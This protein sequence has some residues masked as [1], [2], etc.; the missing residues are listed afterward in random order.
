MAPVD[1]FSFQPAEEPVG[2]GVVRAASRRARAVLKPVT[3]VVLENL[4]G[5]ISGKMDATCIYPKMVRRG[6]SM[7]GSTGA[8]RTTNQRG[9]G[10]PYVQGPIYEIQ[11]LARGWA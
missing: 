4:V 7:E 5:A 8:G 3:L 9:L 1:G 11:Y 6:D 2:G 10:I